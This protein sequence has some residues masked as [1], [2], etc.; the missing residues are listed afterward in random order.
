[1]LGTLSVLSFCY[2]D[3]FAWWEIRIGQLGTQYHFVI[4]SRL[5]LWYNASISLSFCFLY[6]Q[7][8]EASS[9]NHAGGLNV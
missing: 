9:E 3:L 6:V 5:F 2:R 7:R 4:T 8:S 1:M